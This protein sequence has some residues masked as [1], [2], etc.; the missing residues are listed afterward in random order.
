MKEWQK[1]NITY[2]EHVQYDGIY[3]GV[4]MFKDKVLI[5]EYKKSQIILSEEEAEELFKEFIQKYENTG[6]N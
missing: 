4:K 3:Y 2:S 5:G 6:N 1:N